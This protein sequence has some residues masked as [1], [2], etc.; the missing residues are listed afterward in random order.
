MPEIFEISEQLVEM[1]Q[2]IFSRYTTTLEVVLCRVLSNCRCARRSRG[3]AL[4][5]PVNVVCSR[6]IVRFDVRTAN[7]F[8]NGIHAPL[9]MRQDVT[10]DLLFLPLYE[11]DICQ[12][13][14]ILVPR[15]ELRYGKKGSTP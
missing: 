10:S 1:V 15:G 7:A 5:N 11:L 14:F 2:Y 12:H 4:Q 3:H 6:P 8:E 13:T 9:L